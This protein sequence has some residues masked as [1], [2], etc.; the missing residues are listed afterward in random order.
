MPADR[1]TLLAALPLGLQ[2]QTASPEPVR[3]QAEGSTE[4]VVA[5]LSQEAARIVD[6]S[7]TVNPAANW[8]FMIVSTFLVTALGWW[9]TERFVAAHPDHTGTLAVLLTSDEEGDAIDGVRRSGTVS[10][11]GVYGGTADPRAKGR[12][13]VG[14]ATPKAIRREIRVAEGDDGDPSR[15]ERGE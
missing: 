5:G 11:S 6:P 14:H 3:T 8:Y 15:G 10:I 13:R 7:Y 4:Q 12:D 2:S 1:R 9:V